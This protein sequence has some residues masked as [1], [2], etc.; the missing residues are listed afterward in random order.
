M[1]ALAR[2]LSKDLLQHAVFRGRF[3][4]RLP[5][6]RIALTFDD[7]PHPEHTPAMLDALALSG[8]RATFFVVG[9]EVEK[10]PEV[11]RRI[12]AEG[13]GIGGHSQDHTV[14]TSLSPEAL[15]ADL[16]RCRAAIRDATGLD[17]ALFRP[18][19]GEVSLRAIRT[20]CNAGYTLVHWTRTYSDYR[21]DGV[22]RLLGR[23]DAHPPAAGD[24]LLFHDHNAC[25][26]EAL[27]RRLP[28]W[29]DEKLAF[30][31]LEHLFG[32][33]ERPMP[34]AIGKEL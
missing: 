7:G 1:L 17:T 15:V 29:G 26:V 20:A 3:L 10:H 8:T 30:E 4:W 6:P 24:I 25:T 21:Q 13:H 31:P 22:E 12:V 2:N 33:H 11:A 18:P 34:A 9:R 14:M 32:R 5:R 19:K 23:L 27:G 28:R 16:A